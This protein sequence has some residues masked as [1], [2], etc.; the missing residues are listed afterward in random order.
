M[1]PRRVRLP[2]GTM[3]VITYDDRGKKQ[4]TYESPKK[5]KPKPPRGT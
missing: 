5:K 3:Q 2:G 1:K 4:V